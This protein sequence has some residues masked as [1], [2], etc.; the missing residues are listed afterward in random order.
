MAMKK[1][2]FFV[3]ISNLQELALPKIVDLLLRQMIAF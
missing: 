2:W 1:D 3:P